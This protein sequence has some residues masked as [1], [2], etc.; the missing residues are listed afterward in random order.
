MKKTVDLSKTEPR[1]AQ[2][3]ALDTGTAPIIIPNNSGIVPILG[4]RLNASFQDAK[5]A[6]SSYTT[7]AVSNDEYSYIWLLNPTLDTPPIWT[8]PTLNPQNAGTVCD[9]FVGDG[10][11]R[12]SPGNEGVK[13]V[14]GYESRRSAEMNNYTQRTRSLGSMGGVSNELFLCIRE[15]NNALTVF[16]SIMRD[17]LF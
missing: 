2:L 5:L 14:S 17:E 3:Y 15:V 12:I 1:E 9:V 10:S 7:L 6:V 4:I 8:P 13:L 16:A 11:Q